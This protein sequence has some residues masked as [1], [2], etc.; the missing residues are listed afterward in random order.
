MAPKNVNKAGG[1]RSRRLTS[2]RTCR[3]PH[4]S[5]STKFVARSTRTG[6]RCRANKSQ[7]NF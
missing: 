7:R 4:Y 5:D 6:V 1:S 2:S 3:G